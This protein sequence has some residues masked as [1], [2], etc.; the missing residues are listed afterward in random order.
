MRCA[1]LSAK[2]PLSCNLRGSPN[3]IFRPRQRSRAL[4]VHTW[5]RVAVVC[6][7]QNT[8]KRNQHDNQF[9]CGFHRGAIRFINEASRDVMKCLGKR[10][11]PF[12]GMVSPLGLE[13]RT[14]ALKGHLRQCCIE[15][16]R[17]AQPCKTPISALL[18][19]HYLERY[20]RRD[21]RGIR[22]SCIT[23][24]SQY[25]RLVAQSL[26]LGRG[27]PAASRM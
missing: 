19:L 7:V 10:K 13:P 26:V 14:H 5:M 22:R 9:D 2:R 17:L 18:F 4:P 24:V 15:S 1:V 3:L 11:C 16:H 21:L 6:A 12:G 8:A 25:R 27:C 20:R 23:L